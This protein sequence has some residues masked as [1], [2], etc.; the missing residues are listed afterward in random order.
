MIGRVDGR[1][2]TAALRGKN[3]NVGHYMQ[4]FRPI[5]FIPAMFIGAIDFSDHI[6]LS[7]TV[8]LVW[9]HKVI[10]KQSLL[11]SF[12]FFLFFF[13]FAHFS[14]EWDEILYSVEAILS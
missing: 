4:I 3:F 10:A 7:V 12:F 9:G 2:E 6:P 5:C 8:T 14:T 11:V 1:A 13:F